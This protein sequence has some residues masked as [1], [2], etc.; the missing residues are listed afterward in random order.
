MNQEAANTQHTLLNE[1][2]L[3]GANGLEHFRFYCA[4]RITCQP[5]LDL[6]LCLAS[7]FSG[8]LLFAPP[9]PPAYSTG[10]PLG[11]PNSKNITD[12]LHPILFP[13][14]L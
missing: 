5:P 3:A 12:E 7:L 6:Y 1:P 8:A 2:E 4:E 9:H 13:I 14:P 11:I 10:W